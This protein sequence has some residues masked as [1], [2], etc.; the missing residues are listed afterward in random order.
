MTD[1]ATDG[2]CGLSWDDSIITGIT[3]AP[4]ARCPFE[5]FH[6]YDDNDECL[7]LEVGDIPEDYA[8]TPIV[9]LEGMT[10]QR[11]SRMTDFQRSQLRD[12]SD[13][14]TQLLGLEGWRV[15]VDTSYG[16]TRRFIVGRSTGWKPI[17]IELS[18]RDSRGGMGASKE[19]EAVRKVYQVR[20][21]SYA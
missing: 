4:S 2:S 21:R 9:T 7:P 15:E 16:K 3:P 12:Y 11:W 13:L 19:Y 5:Y 20:E 14:T 10:Y 6:K 17:H 1:I 18:R 8:V